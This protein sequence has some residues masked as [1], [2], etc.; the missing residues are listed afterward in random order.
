MAVLSPPRRLLAI[1]DIETTGLVKF[2][3]TDL[4]FPYGDYFHKILIPEHE[5][6]EIGAVL[7]NPNIPGVVN[8]FETKVKVSRGALI[9]S[10]AREINGYNED[11]WRDAPG[12]TE[13][14]QKFN[15]WTRDAK[16]A[17]WNGFFDWG[18]LETAFSL[19]GL[20]PT[21]DYHRIELCSWAI[22]V[23]NAKG[24]F[25]NSYSQDSVAEYL[26]LG[27]EPKPHRAINGARLAHQIFAKLQNLPFK[28]PQPE[29]SLQNEGG[30]CGALQRKRAE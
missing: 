14:L 13:A 16:F 8:E 1:T 20:Q 23:L 17:A 18:F 6:C 27:K 30:G 9:S 19:C 4:A 24:H 26:S 7:V 2:T 10:E 25:L 3:A 11:E 28:A 15:D 5:I 21:L 22:G 29:A 12:L